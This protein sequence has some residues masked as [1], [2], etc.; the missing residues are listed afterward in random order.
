MTGPGRINQYNQ[1]NVS[2]ENQEQ[3][4]RTK[5][6]TRANLGKYW[7]IFVLI[8]GKTFFF[9]IK[10]IES[11]LNIG[12]LTSLIA[13]TRSKQSFT[14]EEWLKRGNRRISGNI[15]M[16]CFILAKLI[17]KKYRFLPGAHSP[18]E[19][20]QNVLQE[21]F[22]PYHVLSLWVWYH[23]NSSNIVYNTDSQVYLKSYNCNCK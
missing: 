21:M 11:K 8:Q 16:A 14:W 1:N 10:N 20:I 17:F 19:F 18:S 9:L 15:L 4:F 12:S 22:L 6:R 23:Q 3:N 13:Q 2:T 5:Q 7:K